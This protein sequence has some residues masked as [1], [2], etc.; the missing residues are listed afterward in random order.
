MI[1][2]ASLG[3]GTATFLPR[4]GLAGE[5]LNDSPQAALFQSAV[6]QGIVY[7]DTASGYGDSEC[8]LGGM[9]DLLTSRRVRLCT[10]LT[11]KSVAE[12]LG[13]SL[14]RLRRDHVD[15]LLLHSAR[16]DE[17][18]DQAVADAL[19]AMKDRR[20]TQRTGA[21]TYGAADAQLALGQPWCDVVQVEHSILNPSVVTVLERAKRSNQEIVVRSVLCKGLL[22][23]R[24]HR[25]RHL[26]ASAR[27]MLDRIESRAF[28]WGMDL[29]ELGVRFALDT[30]GVDVVLVGISHPAEL[31]KALAAAQRPPL[32]AWQMES[33]EEFDCSMQDWSHPERWLVPT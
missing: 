23:A 25:A 11:P 33:L 12:G 17:L 21:S 30:P 10:K 8:V 27:T 15:T 1:D 3:V 28:E 2:R 29:E 31:E 5:E 22:T 24:R 16:G 6:E 13:E 7:I 18:T 20:H 4:Y 26:D 9:A 19:A 32:D 14:R